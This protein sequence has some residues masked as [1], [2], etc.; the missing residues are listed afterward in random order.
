MQRRSDGRTRARK[1]RTMRPEYGVE[2]RFQPFVKSARPSS[3]R[4][5]SKDGD[6]RCRQCVDSLSQPAARAASSLLLARA[7]GLVTIDRLAQPV[8]L[9]VDMAAFRRGQVSV[10]R[11][12]IGA[13]L[14][15]Q[16][17]LARFKTACFAGRQLA[18]ANALG[19]AVLLV[20]AALVHRNWL[21]VANTFLLLRKS[22][23]RRHQDRCSECEDR[24]FQGVSSVGPWLDCLPMVSET[25]GFYE[26]CRTIF[27][28]VFPQHSHGRGFVQRGCA[29]FHLA[30]RSCT[31]CNS[32]TVMR[33]PTFCRLAMY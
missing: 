32:S 8:L 5:G 14:V 25:H 3:E 6:H 2:F 20:F 7:I 26:I 31:S 10:V 23:A 33:V 1:G 22:Q 18:R 29:A 15:V 28:P 24:A 9:A 16:A 4:N 19:G 21:V 17:G 11:I 12:A 30:T 13:D 27:F